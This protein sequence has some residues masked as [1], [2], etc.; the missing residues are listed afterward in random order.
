MRANMVPFVE[1]ILSEL[2]G[3]SPHNLTVTSSLSEEKCM[4]L[5]SSETWKVLERI[6]CT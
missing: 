4:V 5:S 2:W 6:S 3:S 1:R